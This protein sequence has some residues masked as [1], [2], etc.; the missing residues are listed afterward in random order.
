VR[1]DQ[2][3]AADAIGRLIAIDWRQGRTRGLPIALMKAVKNNVEIA[4]PRA[5]MSATAPP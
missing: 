4:A 5:R 1:L 3:T 2:S